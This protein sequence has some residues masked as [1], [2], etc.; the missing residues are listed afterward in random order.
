MLSFFAH[1]YNLSVIANYF[2]TVVYTAELDINNFSQFL[3]LPPLRRLQATRQWITATATSRTSFPTAVE[4]HSTTTSSV[5]STAISSATNITTNINTNTNN[6]NPTTVRRLPLSGL[7]S[8][9]S[10]L[11]PTCSL[12]QNHKSDLALFM[13]EIMFI[14]LYII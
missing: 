5:N 9:Y 2:Y 13:Y 4:T 11:H 8:A 12:N 10:R 14:M 1:V 7:L 3:Q 6:R